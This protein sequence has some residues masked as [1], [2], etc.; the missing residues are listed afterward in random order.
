MY[1]KSL[2]NVSN[3]TGITIKP[4]NA[5][6]KMHVEIVLKSTTQDSAKMRQDKNV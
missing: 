2:A 5:K 4:K 6:I 3:V 1:L